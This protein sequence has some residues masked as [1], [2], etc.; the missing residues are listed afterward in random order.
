MKVTL[1]ETSLPSVRLPIAFIG[2]NEAQLKSISRWE[3]ELVIPLHGMCERRQ[4]EESQLLGFQ[5]FGGSLQS[6]ISGLDKV[7]QS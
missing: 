3:V 5:V 7:K 2:V 4:A 1:G 6:W